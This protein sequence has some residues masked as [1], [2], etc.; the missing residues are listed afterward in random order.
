MC[1]QDMSMCLYIDVRA[2]VA[3]KDTRRQQNVGKYAKSV[4]N[5]MG[6]G[7]GIDDVCC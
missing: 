5:R 7:I 3:V 2:N 1:Y 6:K 4:I